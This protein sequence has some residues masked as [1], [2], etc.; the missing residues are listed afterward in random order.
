MRVVKSVAPFAVLLLIVFVLGLLLVPGSSGGP[1]LFGLS[2]D[3]RS[4]LGASLFGGAIVGIAVLGAELVFSWQ[5]AHIEEDRSRELTRIEKEREAVAKREGLRL[6]L[7]L[8]TDFTGIDLFQQDLRRFYLPGRVFAKANL[9]GASLDGAI[10]WNAILDGARLVETSLQNADLNGASFEGAN[11]V[12]ADLS[13]ARLR[14]AKFNGAHLHEAKLRGADL[15][16]A[17]FTG[18]KL[19]LKST[20]FSG[21][22]WL[23][24][25]PPVWPSEYPQPKNNWPDQNG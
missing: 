11:L 13:E 17:D 19:S 9:S 22:V 24:E 4:E 14:N 6:Q 21:V 16:G 5:L 8:G 3:V 25:E 20:D 18:A 12:R 23:P 1:A 2:A 7:G 15:A 10:L